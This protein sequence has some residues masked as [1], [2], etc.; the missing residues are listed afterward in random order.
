MF[1]S[2]IWPIDRTL[3]G[4]ICPGQS[5]A[6]SDERVLHIPPKAP[7][8]LEPYDQFSVIS[9]R[10]FGRGRMQSCSWCILQPPAIWAKT[11]HNLLSYNFV[12]TNVCSFFKSSLIHWIF[13]IF[14]HLRWKILTFPKSTSMKWNASSTLQGLNAD[15]R[16]HF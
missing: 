13:P 9:R 10:F 15:Y 12:K 7:A 14:T 11:M 3:S 8:L 4:A 5:G 2:S 6:G 16:F 1:N